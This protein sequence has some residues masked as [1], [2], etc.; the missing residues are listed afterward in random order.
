MSVPRPNVPE[1][2]REACRSGAEVTNAKFTPEQRSAN[3]RQGALKTQ[4]VLGRDRVAELISQMS[5]AAMSVV[6][7]PVRTTNLAT[8][9]EKDHPSITASANF[10]G[11]SKTTARVALSKGTHVKGHALTKIRGS[12]E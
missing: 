3:A 8:G 7:Q 10:L 9:E 6:S 4:Q 11:V 5:A 12:E 2:V 1:R